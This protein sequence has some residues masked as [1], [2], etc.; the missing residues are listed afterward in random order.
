M[1]IFCIFLQVFQFVSLMCS[2]FGHKL[3][4]AGRENRKIINESYT[5]DDI[6]DDNPNSEELLDFN[7]NNLSKDENSDNSTKL[8]GS[9]PDY[10]SLIDGIS[11][12][13]EVRTI[14]DLECVDF[15]KEMF[16]I[17]NP[18]PT[19]PKNAA[20]VKIEKEHSNMAVDNNVR[21]IQKETCCYCC[22]TSCRK[23]NV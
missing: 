21:F 23:S 4:F 22:D 17:I 16:N 19:S 13:D 6:H 10:I 7:F 20:I 3:E 9:S 1:L 12:P 5:F 2:D 8:D 15:E 14:S 18:V 11:V